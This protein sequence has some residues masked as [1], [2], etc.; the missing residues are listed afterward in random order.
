M[1]DEKTS[2]TIKKEDFSSNQTSLVKFIETV[3][4]T[5][6]GDWPECYELVLH[7]AQKMAWRA[8]STKA[9]LMV[10][11]AIPHEAHDNPAKLDWR[12]EADKLR[13]LGIVV[14]SVQALDAGNSQARMFWQ[15][16]AEKTH[17]YHLRLD[18]FA[19]IRDVLLAVC[20]KQAGDERVQ[21]YEQEITSRPSGLSRSMRQ[22]E[23]HEGGQTDSGVGVVPGVRAMRC[24]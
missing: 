3:S 4:S 22:S 9:L 5:G 24:M 15:S 12:A 7:E 14:Y 17:G 13:D 2:Y 20:L 19:Y 16:I 18:Q 10:G 1:Q 6:G 8:G 23:N 21:A 11:D